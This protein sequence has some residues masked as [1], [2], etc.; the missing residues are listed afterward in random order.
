MHKIIF[1]C[2]FFLYFERLRWG[3]WRIKINLLKINYVKFKLT[4]WR[5]DKLTSQSY[6][7][8]LFRSKWAILTC[9]LVYLSTRQLRKLHFLMELS[10]AR[11]IVINQLNIVGSLIFG[12][13]IIWV[14]TNNNSCALSFKD[15]MINII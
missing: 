7:Y 9:L 5:V 14:L 2:N 8:G 3:K 12:L 15:I 1:L 4:S 6:L 13:F 11:K 10:I